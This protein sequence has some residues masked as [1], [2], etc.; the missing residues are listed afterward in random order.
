MIPL[1]PSS[2]IAARSRAGSSAPRG[3]LNIRTIAV[4][5]DVDAALPFVREADEAVLIGPA[6]GA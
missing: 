1:A 6:P 3:V 5:S 4:Y 2:P